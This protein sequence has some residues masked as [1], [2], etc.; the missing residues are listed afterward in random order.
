MKYAAGKSDWRQ[1]RPSTP[2]KELFLFSGDIS[3][4]FSEVTGVLR[5]AANKGPRVPGF[6]GSR[7]DYFFK[8]FTRTLESLNP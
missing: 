1:R 5:K 7:V 6:K 4:L 3:L 8:I 2:S